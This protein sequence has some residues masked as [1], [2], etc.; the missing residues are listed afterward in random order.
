MISRILVI[1]LSSL[2]DIIL[3]FPL[4]SK[5]KRKY[6]DSE[7]TFLSK[8]EYAELLDLNPLID[9]VMKLNSVNSK[10]DFDIVIDLQN[11][12]RSRRFLKNFSG[13]IF[14]YKKDNL[15]KFLLVNFKV[16]LF[17]EVVPVYEK[18]IRSLDG[19]ISDFSFE[20]SMLDYRKERVFENEYTIIAPCSRHF[21]KT[22]PK[23]KFIEFIKA[24]SNKTFVLVGSES[25]I[26]ISIC[27]FIS[28]ECDNVLNYCGKANFG[29]L[30]N[31]IFN[32]ERVITND[33]SILHLSEAI[34][35]PVTALFGSTVKQFGF[36]PQLENSVVIENKDLKC[37]PCSHI[38]RS[39]CPKKHFRC[40]GE[41]LINN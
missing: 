38:G 2:G 39:S 5:L 7:I 4:L 41:L 11:N 17:K 26:D 6:P 10:N 28:S 20:S 30:C 33:S 27:N 12:F 24:N 25:Q 3:S 15:E 36:F 9:T 35:K 29:E 14:R 1:R 21:T 37:R 18:Y 34:G 16:D 22:Y 19:M 31:L 23:E 40:M 8:D 13:K 32:S